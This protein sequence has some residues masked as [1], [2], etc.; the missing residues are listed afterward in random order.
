MIANIVKVI[1]VT[2][3]I[4]MVGLPTLAQETQFPDEDRLAQKLGALIQM[5]NLPWKVESLE[6]TVEGNAGT[7]VVPVVEQRFVA[8]MSAVETI[9]ETN[10][11]IAT[12]EAFLTILHPAGT[13]VALHGV[14]TSRIQ[15]ADWGTDFGFDT[16]ADLTG[17]KTYSYFAGRVRP[18]SLFILST[19][20]GEAAFARVEERKREKE[21]AEAE[22]IEREKQRVA[23]I[24]DELGGDWAGSVSCSMPHQMTATMTIVTP[25]EPNRIPG[26]LT[27]SNPAT[28]A[29]HE[30]IPV[31]LNASHHGEP[32]FRKFGSRED[33]GF[34]ALE[35]GVLKGTFWGSCDVL[36]ERPE[37]FKAR[38]DQISAEVAAFLSTVQV[39]KVS[40]TQIGPKR[41]D[42]SEWP[43]TGTAK[44]NGTAIE[45]TL[46]L[47]GFGSTSSIKFPYGPEAISY[48]LSFP[49]GLSKPVF[50]VAPY[51]K[52]KSDA[53]TGVQ[54]GVKDQYSFQGRCGS[55]FAY[56]W[57]PDS[58]KITLKPQI[59]SCFEKTTLSFQ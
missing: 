20:E 58:M 53:P 27:L 22:A 18:E 45:G 8:T 40:G 34:I 21:R 4:F 50:A 19:P 43:I 2:A 7:D 12:P 48:R 42:D 1:S 39:S 24:N 9:F 16:T 3:V 32:G 14:A 5:N 6:V 25:F 29:V 13:E 47:W 59:P 38:Q 37:A 23:A 33:R 15:N 36:F 57:E 56:D 46:N 52:M 26:T 28:G 51:E 11:V 49:L 10:M 31:S 55:S 54:R 41:R 17:G 30:D 44:V 35:D